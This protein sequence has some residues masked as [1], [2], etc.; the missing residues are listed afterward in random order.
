MPSVP[1][2]SAQSLPSVNRTVAGRHLE[3]QGSTTQRGNKVEGFRKA[4][5]VAAQAESGACPDRTHVP[6]SYSSLTSF[7]LNWQSPP[8]STHETL[9]KMSR[10]RHGP[11]SRGKH[12]AHHIFSRHRAPGEPGVHRSG[13]TRPPFMSPF[14]PC[15]FLSLAHYSSHPLSPYTSCPAGNVVV[16]NK[17]NP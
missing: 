13:A 8:R 9:R 1:E 17:H 11:S 16:N 5:S 4:A 6:A 3:Q 2:Q 15:H 12:A 7:S 14:L 10:R